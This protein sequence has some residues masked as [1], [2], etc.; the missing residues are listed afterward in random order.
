MYHV[1]DSCPHF[2]CII[3]FYTAWCCAITV[4]PRRVMMQPSIASRAPVL[5]PTGRE[6][7]TAP[8]AWGTPFT[9]QSHTRTERVLVLL[10]AGLPLSTINT[11]NRYSGCS[12]RRKPARFVSTD[13]VLSEVRGKAKRQC[14]ERAQ[15]NYVAVRMHLNVKRVRLDQNWSPDTGL[16][17]K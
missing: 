11:G 12:C 6:K 17:V 4:L 7:A 5:R 14:L 10:K 15:W 2:S 13:A 8:H 9:P 16:R 3:S 1:L